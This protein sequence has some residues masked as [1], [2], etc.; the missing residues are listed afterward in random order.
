MLD[1]LV[2]SHFFT[3]TKKPYSEIFDNVYL[4]VC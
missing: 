4:G 1:I 3:F 2:V